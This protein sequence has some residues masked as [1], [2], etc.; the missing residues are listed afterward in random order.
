MTITTDDMYYLIRQGENISIEMKKCSDTY[1]PISS[2]LTMS[3]RCGFHCLLLEQVKVIK[4][5]VNLI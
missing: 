1:V 2:N 3:R 5:Q 4:G